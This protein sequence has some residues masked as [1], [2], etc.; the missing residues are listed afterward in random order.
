MIK[1]VGGNQYGVVEYVVSVP[2]EIDELP[3]D[4]LVAQGS[5]AF[6]IS[7]SQVFMYDEENDFWKEI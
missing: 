2:S 5:T 6:V 3:K 1:K 7:T 4:H